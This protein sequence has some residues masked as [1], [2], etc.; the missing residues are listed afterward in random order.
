MHKIQIHIAELQNLLLEYQKQ[1]VDCNN[2]NNMIQLTQELQSN[3]Q[4]ILISKLI[5]LNLNLQFEALDSHQSSNYN[6]DL[7]IPESIS[8]TLQIIKKILLVQTV[9]Q[10]SRPLN[11][12]AI[13]HSAKQLNQC[14][15]ELRKVINKTTNLQIS[16][17]SDILSFKTQ[18]TNVKLTEI[19][20][21]STKII[22]SQIDQNKQKLQEQN[23]E[24]KEIQSGIQNIENT[25][26]SQNA[27]VQVLTETTEEL[28][29]T[30]IEHKGQ[31]NEL[32]RNL[33]DTQ[34][35]YLQT[36]KMVQSRLSLSQ[37]Q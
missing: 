22:S 19:D 20:L 23:I 8:E 13:Q 2:I 14:T 15:N 27:K 16:L 36:S 34:T 24:I 3:P 4:K 6:S 5:K 21:V 28:I 37:I 18:I 12:I 11:Q 30:Q 29:S 31:V 33:S 10:E 17:N 25:I 26:K 9:A 32:C 7:S 1:A 35:E